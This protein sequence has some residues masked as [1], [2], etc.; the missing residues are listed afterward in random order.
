VCRINVREFLDAHVYKDD[1]K[2]FARD[3]G[4]RVGGSK[5]D[6][7]DRLL[8]E[9]PFEVINFLNWLL[10]DDLKN[11]C[12]SMDLRVGGSKDDLVERI[13]SELE[14]LEEEVVSMASSWF[15]DNEDALAY[16]E[17]W[18]VEVRKKEEPRAEVPSIAPPP[19]PDVASPKIV[20][21]QSPAQTPPEL[22]ARV[23]D[24]INQWIPRMRYGKEEG[25]RVDL[26]GH[27]HA[28]HGFHVRMEAGESQA[29]IQVNDAVPIELKKNPTQANYD[30]L[31][32]QLTRH[33][34]A[35]GCAI[36]V[37]CDVRRLEQFQDFV[38]NVAETVGKDERVVVIQK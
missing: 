3:Q 35:K 26:T 11:I 18:G 22:L 21:P 17:F 7:I 9:G 37:V 36:A 23:V 2:G 33:K 1:L 14:P 8:Q 32:G 30:R 38:H 16:F 27:L 29:D 15:E 20:P 13:L 6:L 25:Y 31:L 5:D 4:V 34:R 28:A 12:Y 10:K 24:A 19:V